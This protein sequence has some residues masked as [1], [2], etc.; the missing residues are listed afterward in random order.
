MLSSARLHLA[1][2]SRDGYGFRCV[3][4]FPVVGWSKAL[5]NLE[6]IAGIYQIDNGWVRCKPVNPGLLV[7]LGK[8]G[9]LVLCNGGVRARFR[10]H[11]AALPW[12]K[13]E[14]R[15]GEAI[16]TPALRYIPPTKEGGAAEMRIEL[17]IQKGKQFVTLGSAPV[18]MRLE[19]AQEYTME[20]CAV[21]NLLIGKINQQTLIARLEKDS[22][23]TVGGLGIWGV[24]RNFFRDLEVINLD[25][26]SE[27]EALKHLGVEPK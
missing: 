7:P 27:A 3:L 13:L 19:D 23:P 15:K 5:P 4:A 8:R 9:N 25:G 26:L 21:G 20:L 17:T 11:V 6:K 2:R 18:E 1:P 14:I 10:G 24:D 16:A 12:A 22:V